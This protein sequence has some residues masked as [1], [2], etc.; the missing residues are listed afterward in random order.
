MP[1]HQGR[2]LPRFTLRQ[3][4]LPEVGQWE[5]NG[6]YYLVMKVEMVGKHN[7]SDIEAS[8][9]RPKIEGV[10]EVHSIRALDDKPVDVKTIEREAF[11]Q[12]VARAK[13]GEV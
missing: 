12:T 6:Q 3:I 8:E 5:V 4:D 1:I 2:E 13:A 11:E 7:R 10:F 9:D